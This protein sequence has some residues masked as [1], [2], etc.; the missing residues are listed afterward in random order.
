[1]DTAAIAYRIIDF[2]KNHPPFSSMA[3]ADL[4]AL[5]ADGRVRFYEPHEY[6]LWQGEPHKFHIFVIQQ[7]SVSLWDDEAT[8][9]TLHDVRGPGDMLG[10]ER[11]NGARSCQHS[12]KSESDV[13]V[14]AF[15]EENFAA[16]LEKYPQARDYVTAYDGAASYVAPGAGREPQQVFLHE[17]VGGRSY[18]TCRPDERISDV[19]RRLVDA[20]AA[21][22]V[23]VDASRRPLDVLTGDHFLRWVASGNTDG[24]QTVTELLRPGVATVATDAL[25]ADG[26]MAMATAGVD[27]VALTTG[28]SAA[29]AVHG[30]V[31]TRDVAPYFGDQPAWIL[32]EIAVAAAPALLR[33]LNLRARAFVLRYLTGAPSVDW[34]SRFSAAV[35]AA[36]VSRLIRLT[37]AEAAAACWCFSGAAGRAESLTLVAPHLI[38]IVGD[39]AAEPAIRLAHQRVTAALLECG[40]L[41]PGAAVVDAGFSVA[42]LDA[43]RRRYREWIADPIMTQMYRARPLFDLR[44]I[45]GPDGL[46]DQLGEVLAA[47]DGAFL[48]VLANDCLATLPPLTFFQDVIVNDAGEQSA[49]FRLEHSALQPLVDVG[50]VFGLAGG[51]VFRQSTLQRFA[52]ARGLVPDHESIFRD[53]SDAFRVVL[54]QQGRVGIGQGTGGFELPPAALSR[55]D[56]HLL[57][58]RFRSIHRLIEFTADFSWLRTA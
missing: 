13:L 24:G 11:F 28:G 32:G 40:Y 18:E 35:D 37:G 2:L 34:L 19:A 26:V 29:A 22:A 53:A 50:R 55:Y 16:L 10:I 49:L 5:T 57:K 48:R 36:I 25:L 43:W 12:V 54:S 33:G 20:G 41:A 7:G 4:L 45:H 44:P 52:A 39:E 42:T 58:S 21:A 9:P 1:M 3:E 56:R 6:L 23:V 51:S 46:L 31:T 17:V 38:V 15:S 30:V 27:A 47:V 8:Q 14:Y